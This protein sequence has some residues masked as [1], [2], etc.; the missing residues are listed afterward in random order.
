MT[1][2]YA[3]SK[4]AP[5]S[6]AEADANVQQ[7]DTRTKDGWADIVS[8][9]YYRDSPSSP[10][11][12]NYKGGLYLPEFLTGQTMEV[13][14]NFH[15]P[16]SW[17]AGTML[18]PHVHFTVLNNTA[19]VV[20][21]G[22]EYTFARRHDSSSHTTFPATQVIVIDFSIPAN[23]ADTH[24]VCEAPEAGGITGTNLEVDAMVLTRIYREGAHANDTYPGSCFGITADLHIEVDRAA[25]PNRAPDFYT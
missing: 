9:L 10:T 6:V 20:R 4:G 11:A 1:I 14:S 13:F 5:L 19:G 16:H 7:F 22:F 24:F 18:Y 2:T 3:A 25:T 12:A 8:E 21:W 23:S 15:I 17:R